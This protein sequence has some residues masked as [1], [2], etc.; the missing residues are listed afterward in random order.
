[1]RVVSQCLLVVALLIVTA[2]SAF[3]QRDLEIPIQFDFIN[4]GARSLSLGGAFIGLADDATAATTNPAGLQRLS[5]PEI[6]VEGRGWNFV[7]DFVKGGRLSGTPTQQG[8]DTV[9]GPVFGESE[10]RV[11]GLSFLSFV[12][13]KGQ[14]SFAGYRQEASRLRSSAETDGAFFTDRD[15]AGVLR[16]YREYPNIVDRE[17][18]VVNYGGSVAYRNGPVYVGGGLHLSQ[19]SYDSTLTGYELPPDF[20]GATTY[21]T[22]RFQNRQE[23][24][25]W[26]VGFTAGVLVIPND[27]FQ[28]GGTYRRGADFETGGTLTYP[29]FPDV[30]GPYTGEFKVPDNFGG[31][32][33]VRPLAGLTIAFDVNRVTYSDLQPFVQSQVRFAEEEAQFYSIDDATEVHVGAEYVLTNVAWLPSVRG[34]YWRETDHSV[35]YSGD[36]ILYQ[37]SATL[38]SDIDHFAFGAGI[39]PNPRFE[40]NAGFDF[41]SRANTMSFSGIIRF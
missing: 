39:A 22:S 29:L 21:A 40:I 1:M 10:E 6:S 30:A 19:L 41:S 23:G 20:F 4:P 8:I 33:A 16:N 17:L 32:V 15:A 11:G 7:T 38:A 3:A 2:S 14:W 18:D 34:G 31:G 25:D 27:K 37:A 36:D 26:G 28:F 24:D 5:R 12:Y 9:N 13:P 35:V